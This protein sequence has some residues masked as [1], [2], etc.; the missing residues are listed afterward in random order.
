MKFK[1]EV[2]LVSALID[3]V[4]C[5]Y[6]TRNNIEIL[7]EVSLG[8]GVADVVITNMLDEKNTNIREEKL[9]LHDINLYDLI[10]KHQQGLDINTMVMI[11]RGSKSKIKTSL[12]KLV[13]LNYIIENNFLYSI[14]NE[15]QFAFKNNFAIEA[16][17]KDWK[18]ALKQAYRY[19]WFAEYSFVVID[20]YYSKKAIENIDVFKKYNVGLI[21]ISPDKGIKKHHYPSPEQPYDNRMKMLLS[22]IIYS[23]SCIC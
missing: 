9:N 5:Q 20:E 13:T 16:K 4:K 17:L 6:K 23:G 12:N 8:F 7:S 14:N 10:S 19:K 18:K 15:Y 2:D 21:T 3:F 1:T 22:E 11:L